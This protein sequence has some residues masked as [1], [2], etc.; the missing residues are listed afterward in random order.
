MFLGASVRLYPAACGRHH[1]RQRDGQDHQRE[2]CRQGAGVRHIPAEPGLPLGR[3]ETKRSPLLA[4]GHVFA[5]HRPQTAG[6]QGGEWKAESLGEP[7]TLASSPFSTV[8][9][10]ARFSSRGPQAAARGFRGPAGTA[11]L[12]GRRGPEGLAD[13][14]PVKLSGRLPKL[15]G[16]HLPIRLLFSQTGTSAPLVLLK[17]GW[18]CVWP[19]EKNLEIGPAAMS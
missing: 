17:S 3:M 4:D 11:P 19:K 18:A 5:Q 6:D 13:K 9:Q 10:I 7:V 15:G 12:G 14:L 16:G 8:T 2:H 1:R